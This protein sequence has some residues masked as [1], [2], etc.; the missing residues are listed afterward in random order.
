MDSW[1]G[2]IAAEPADQLAGQPLHVVRNA[3]EHRPCESFAHIAPEWKVVDDLM[4]NYACL[5][6]KEESAVSDEFTFYF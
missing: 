2:F 3:E 5:I 6:D 1:V 4:L